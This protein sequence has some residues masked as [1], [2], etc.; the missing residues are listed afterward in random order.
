MMSYERFAM[1]LY[2][3][4]EAVL[5]DFLKRLLRCRVEVRRRGSKG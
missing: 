1:L 3:S 4:S 2:I 5:V